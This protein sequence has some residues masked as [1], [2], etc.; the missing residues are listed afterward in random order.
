MAWSTRFKQLLRDK[1]AAGGTSLEGA[2][3]QV[4]A[5]KFR[6]QMGTPI[7]SGNHIGSMEVAVNPKVLEISSHPGCCS[8]S[9]TATIRFVGKH[10]TGY[11]FLYGVGLTN[12]LTFGAQSIN[13]RTFVYTGATLSAG[14]TQWAASAATLLPIGTLAKLQILLTNHDTSGSTVAGWTDIFVGA[15][16][17]MKWNG[18]EYTL[19]FS[20]ALEAAK[21]HFTQQKAY[22]AS[23]LDDD[24]G[25]WFAGCGR[26]TTVHTT[27]SDY[28]DSE[29]KL[30]L[31][32]NEASNSLR[33][34]YTY[35]KPEAWMGSSSYSY[36]SDASTR[37]MWAHVKNSS[38]HDTWVFYDTYSHH[39]SASKVS[40]KGMY[41]NASWAYELPGYDN[42]DGEQRA[43]DGL[44]GIGEDSVVTNV[45]VLAGTPVTELVNTVYFQGYHE[46]MVPGIFARAEWGAYSDAINF[47]DC[48]EAHGYWI[49]MYDRIAGDDRLNVPFRHVVTKSTR[50]GLSLIN[51]LTGKW[52]VFP[53]YKEGG[54]GVG[55]I[56]HPHYESPRSEIERIDRH[57]IEGADFSMRNDQMQGS[58]QGAQ[59]VSKDKD[60]ALGTSSLYGEEKRIRIWRMEDY[61]NK[62]MDSTMLPQ[63]TV[64]TE[65]C[66]AGYDA[67]VAFAR[68]SVALHKAYYGRPHCKA[69]LR[70][71]GLHWAHLSPGDYVDVSVGAFAK[72]WGPFHSWSRGGRMTHVLNTINV[73]ELYSQFDKWLVVSTHVDWLNA[74]CTVVL[75]KPIVATIETWPTALTHSYSG[76]VHEPQSEHV[77]IVEI[78]K[79]SE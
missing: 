2:A 75:T 65:D 45:C 74:K 35:K 63:L 4:Y 28:T 71:R 54:Y 23:H 44:G 12:K 62:S 37:P 11:P 34:G 56:R 13:P 64:K 29:L 42:L 25:M 51:K 46:Q 31:P 39:D 15:Y 69:T 33:F 27:V 36:A 24:R 1:S 5:P 20:D 50:N 14:V 49:R 52:G 76:L 78:E 57:H 9:P 8:A 26:T 72:H 48:I 17:G 55:T 53:R 21:S 41:S 59:Y 32:F 40:L 16:K 3:P 7:V 73:G 58:Y 6:L 30:D 67:G 66:A 22:V 70:L 18:V 61:E 68:Y 77:G 10:D 19:E 38:N 47:D 79:H 60:N 43:A